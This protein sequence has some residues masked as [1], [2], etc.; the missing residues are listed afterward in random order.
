[1]GMIMWTTVDPTAEVRKRYRANGWWDDRALPMLLHDALT[2]SS[3]QAFRVH[4]RS[5]PFSGTVGGVTA[6]ARRFAAGLA[7]R[8]IAAGDPVAFNLPNSAEAAAVFYGLALLGA[9][10]V[11]V[12]YTA[13]TRELNHALRESGARAL[14]VW[15]QTDRPFAFDALAPDL[16]WLE[17]IVAIGDAPSP[18]LVVDFD[19]VIARG[20]LDEPASVDPMQPAVIG[21][22]SGTTGDPKGALLSHRTLCAEVRVHMSPMMAP[23]SRPLAS[24]S[25]IAQVTGMLVSVLVPPLLGHEIHLLDYWDAGEVLELMTTGSLSAGTGA[26][27]F[28]ASLLDHPACTAKHHELIEMSS[29]GGAAVPDE[30]VLRAERAGIVAMRG[31]G[32]TEH[33]SIAL[34]MADDPAPKRAHTDGRL[35]AGVDVRIVGDDGRDVPVGGPGEIYSRGPDLF[36]GYT[37]PSLNAAV[38]DGGWYRTGDIGRLDDEGYLTVVDRKKD[39]VIRAGMNI[40]PAE[41][42]AAMT[43][44]LDIADI[45]VIAVPDARTGERACAFVRPVPGREPPT[46]DRVRQHLS[47]AGVA[48]YK[49]PEEICGYR[50]DFP[51]TPAGKVRKTELRAV[52]AARHEHSK[53]DTR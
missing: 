32:C 4:S 51:R 11:P 38:F 41:I 29:L 21:W 24:T 36:C 31:Y 23:R 50:D 30:L 18:A 35:C 28:L 42:E 34:G 43:S 40:S 46:L 49:W 37:D 10:L 17:H 20:M 33:P 5:R 48:K 13:G 19:H 6:H 47:T 39:I 26:P 52:W 8:G 9:T 14:V 45:A 15:H 7:R 2:T 12:G 22:T 3:G 27:L 1:M 25:P 16:P 53:E 44:M